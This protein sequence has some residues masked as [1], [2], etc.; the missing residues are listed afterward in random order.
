M[1]EA[2]SF[3]SIR[4]RLKYNVIVFMYRMVNDMMPEELNGRISRGY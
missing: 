3:M 2:L 1:L 4:E